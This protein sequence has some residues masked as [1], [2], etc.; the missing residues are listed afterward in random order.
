[1]TIQI[2]FEGRS[3]TFVI[4][5]QCQDLLVSPGETANVRFDLRADLSC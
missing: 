2:A 1:M 3:V 5:L 4:L